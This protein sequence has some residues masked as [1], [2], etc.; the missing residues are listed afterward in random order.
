[1]GH[2]FLIGDVVEEDEA[3]A[4]EWFQRAANQ[5]HEYAQRTLAEMYEEGRGV[6]KNLNTALEWYK[7]AAAQGDKISQENAKR[8]S[9]AV[10]WIFPVYG[11][12][13]G[14]STEEQVEAKSDK[15]VKW[16]DKDDIYTYYI[17][18]HNFYCWN[19][20]RILNRV[21]FH[22]PSK[23][24][25]PQEIINKGYNPNYSLE[26]WETFLS[27]QGYDV[28]SYTDFI[29]AKKETPIDHNITIHFDEND[30]IRYLSF[31]FYDF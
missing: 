20:Q 4:A 12:T 17:N 23:N 30:K 21:H 22:S 1:M 10:K 29:D 3:K 24:P 11:L 27:S 16:K 28:D 8:L 7:K 19:E 25:W 9:L 6:K 14:E 18:G 2:Y 15:K 5:G 13:L 31:Y 26:E